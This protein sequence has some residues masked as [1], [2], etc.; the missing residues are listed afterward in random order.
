MKH[1][2]RSFNTRHQQHRQPYKQHV[3]RDRQ[4]RQTHKHDYL[5]YQPLIDLMWKGMMMQFFR[6]GF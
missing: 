4:Y 2:N 5:S 1:P 6:Y 3:P